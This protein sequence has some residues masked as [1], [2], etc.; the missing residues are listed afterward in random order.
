MLP[1]IKESESIAPQSVMKEYI[2]ALDSKDDKFYF[3]MVAN[4]EDKHGI[5]IE[6]T[7][8]QKVE[9][10]CRMFFR[11]SDVEAYMET[12]AIFAEGS[13][14]SVKQ[15][16]TTPE[17]LVEAISKLSEKNIKDGGRGFQIVVSVVHENCIKNLDV[18]WT[19]D[20]E[21]MV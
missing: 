20:K 6:K 15:I 19:S 9:G 2:E 7:F 21:I 14:V 8:N 4:K 11:Q 12:I 16:E 13:V 17:F 3:C 1:L 5:Y 18:F 10:T